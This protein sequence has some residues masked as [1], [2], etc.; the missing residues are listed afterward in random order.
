[1]A[2]LEYF[3]VRR[4]DRDRSNPLPTGDAASGIA[5]EE[6]PGRSAGAQC[7]SAEG[8]PEGKAEHP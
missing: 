4:S 1:M 6:P 2:W 8:D 7:L 5:G 3:P